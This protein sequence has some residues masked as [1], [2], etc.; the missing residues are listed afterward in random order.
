MELISSAS[1]EAITAQTS[2]NPSPG[3][4]VVYSGDRPTILVMGRADRAATVQVSGAIRGLYAV[5]I[6][7]LVVDVSAAMDCEP[8]LLTVLARAHARLADDSG[9]LKI[10]GVQL[11]QFVSALRT[12]ALDEVFVIYDAM[13]REGMSQIPRPRLSTARRGG[14]RPLDHAI[15]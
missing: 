13:R 7:H 10:V 4:A 1:T 11:P 2:T 9:T 15:S 6:R 8:G 5:G 12:A 3:W 14:A